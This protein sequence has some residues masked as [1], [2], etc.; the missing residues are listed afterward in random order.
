LRAFP[1]AIYRKTLIYPDSGTPMLSPAYDLLSTIP[2]IQNWTAALKYARTRKM[3]EFTYDELS[4]LA[5]KAGVADRPMRQTARRTVEEFHETWTREKNHLGLANAV[6]D[7][8]DG[9][10]PTLSLVSGR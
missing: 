3:S 7:A 9:H 10:L 5:A 6:I 1:K 8:V 4:Y 2:Y